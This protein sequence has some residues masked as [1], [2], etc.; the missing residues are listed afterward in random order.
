MN[1]Y[2]KNS[3]IESLASRFS[4]PIRTVIPIVIEAGYVAQQAN[5]GAKTKTGDGYRSIVTE[6][7]QNSEAVLVRSLL[8]AFP[9]A[10]ILSEEDTDNQ[11]MLSKDCPTGL[12]EAELAFII[13][14]IDGTASYGSYL[15]NWCVS[16][17]MMMRGKLIGGVVYAPD[18]NGG[19]LLVSEERIGA[20]VAE[21]C[22]LN[23]CRVT[24]LD[25]FIT[26]T[27]AKNSV[28]FRGVDSDLYAPIGE[29]FSRNIAP[30]IRVTGI[31]NSGI[32]GLAQVACGR[33]TA[34]IQMP[35]RSWDWAGAYRAV[36]ATGRIFSFFRLTPD[37]TASNS[38]ILVEVGENIY[39]FDAFR[40]EKKYR[41]GYVAGEPDM[42]RRLIKFLP[43]KGLSL[44]NPETIFEVWE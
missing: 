12:M 33:L 41:L 16:V 34:V 20:V 44:E 42:V 3:A 39:D 9:E 1:F 19:M 24:N 22:L 38:A 11:N 14:P 10:L 40:Y 2:F 35:Q 17:G 5:R 29:L 8:S 31:T 7:D 21:N 4:P 37:P 36:L 28:V 32:L 27:A 43:R 23:D 13:D 15:G 6:G 26:P 18:L 25:L 30:M